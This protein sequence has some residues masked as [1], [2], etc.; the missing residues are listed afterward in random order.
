MGNRGLP[1]E[2]VRLVLDYLAAGL[3]P[4]QAGP[5]AGVSKS[6]AY[7][8]HHKMGGLYRPPAVTYS[9]RYLNREE[10]YE[11]ARLRESGLSMRQIAGRLARSPST[12]SRELARNAGPR[13][14]GYQPERAHRLACGA[15][16][17]AQAVTAVAA[18]GITRA[19]AADAGSAVLPR[20]DRQD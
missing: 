4:N 19:G 3:N 17:Q 20:A 11:L 14:R 13:A 9:D 2:R 15:A 7:D 5:A 10:R 18:P 1:R 6:F 8:L 16:A 12:V